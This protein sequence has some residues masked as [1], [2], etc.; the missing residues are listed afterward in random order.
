M[1]QQVKNTLDGEEA[2]WL[3]LLADALHEDGQVVMVVQLVHLDLPSDLVRGSVLNLD[4]QIA[5]IVEA[6][7]LARGNYACLPGISQRL[8]GG[9]LRQGLVQGAWVAARAL[10]LLRVHCLQQESN[11]VNF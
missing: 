4:W 7:E 6:T 10:T 2:V 1:V 9:D 3:L 11:E 5:T 8:L